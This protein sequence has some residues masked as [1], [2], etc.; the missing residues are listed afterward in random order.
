M[1]CYQWRICMAPRPEYPFGDRSPA[2]DDE[3]REVLES[4]LGE[5]QNPALDTEGRAACAALLTHLVR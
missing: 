5:L 3:R 2:W 4:V 1:T